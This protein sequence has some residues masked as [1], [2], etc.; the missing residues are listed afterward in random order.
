MNPTHVFLMILCLLCAQLVA[1]EPPAFLPV[2][3]LPERAMMPDPFLKP[4]GSRVKSKDE[5]P[6]QRAY[7]KALME[8][9][10]YGT[11]PPRPTEQDLSFEIVSDEPYSPPQSDIAGRKQHIRL[12]IM[13]SGKSHS[14]TLNLWRRAEVRRY[15]VLINNH[16]EHSPKNPG[17][18]MAEGLRRGYAVV[19]F[20]RTEVA[21]DKGGN[22]NRREG[23]FPLYPEY[24]FCTIGAWAWAY[25][26]VMDVLDRMGVA[27]M[28]KIIA[29]GHSR[30]G[31]TAMAA[32]IFDERI[33]IAAP[34][35]GGPFSLGSTRQRD[36]AGY[37]GTTDYA[38]NFLK[39]NPHWFHPRYF[40]FVGQQ[41]RQPWDVS[42]LAA[43]VAPRALLNV[44]AVADGINN[45]LAHEVG[46]RVGREIY[47]W[48]D[49]EDRVRLHWRD[50]DNRWGQKG[51][52]QGPEEFLAI[53][54]FAD[55]HFF[56]KPRGPSSYNVA[57]QS[58]TW[59]YD[60]AKFPLMIDWSMPEP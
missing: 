56:A 47:R 57:P 46:V 22:R 53:F 31:Q 11:I 19:E 14:F 49:A 39:A 44:N 5:W 54:D 25:Q 50:K 20:E 8:H 17:F 21:P 60:P 35:T 45:G 38:A 2:T 48:W 23:I 15:P 36:P 40:E 6:T 27:D 26:P 13:R 42:T 10:L 52:D 12:T 33:A 30:G 51:H 18:S 4:D 29:T 59:R 37:R 9:Y 3:E 58:D 16:P 1:A 41:N 7:L 28:E 55:E 34:S 43:L 24:D 32:A